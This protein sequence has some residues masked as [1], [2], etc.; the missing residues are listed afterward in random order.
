MACSIV[1]H[2]LILMPECWRLPRPITR[3]WMRWQAIAKVNWVV[4]VWRPSWPL[5]D[6][7]HAPERQPLFY[8]AS[9]R[10]TYVILLLAK[11]SVH[12]YGRILSQLKRGSSGWLA[13]WFPKVES[14]L[15]K[16]PLRLSGNRDAAFY[17]LACVR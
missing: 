15:M 10:I 16:E 7:R 13:I 4:V 3:T 12:Y 14:C 5:P 1:I 2:G 11:V 17:L 8:L 9:T 6:V